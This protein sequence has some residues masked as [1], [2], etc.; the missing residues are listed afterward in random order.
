[1]MNEIITCGQCQFWQSMKTAEELGLTAQWNGNQPTRDD[2]GAC[3]APTTEPVVRCI[4]WPI[5]GWMM[6]R[7]EAERRHQELVTAI[8]SVIEYGV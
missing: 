6:Q 2:I 1:M 4:D 7:Y 3:F 8:K 5:C